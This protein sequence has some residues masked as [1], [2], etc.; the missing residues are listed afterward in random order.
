[1]SRELPRRIRIAFIL[2]AVM[3]SIAIIVG[4]YAAGSVVKHRL[5]AERMRAEAASYWAGRAADP[6]FPL[7]LT[8]TVSGYFL[9]AGAD[10]ARLPAELRAA[11]PGFDTLPG[12]GRMLLVE[13]RPAGRLYL[14]MSFELV[15]QLVL[16]TAIASN[17][18][19]LQT[20]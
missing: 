6:A 20:L 19:A 9:P 12:D 7:P 8:S 15:D 17:L 3:A 2:Q 13:A 16:W 18:L 5:A 4:I 11:K 1:M 10:R 14:T